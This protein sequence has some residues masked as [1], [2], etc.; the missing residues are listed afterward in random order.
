[1]MR[2]TWLLPVAC[3]VCLFLLGM[4]SVDPVLRASLEKLKP[5]LPGAYFELAEVVADNAKSDEERKLAIRL[6]ALAA[7]LDPDRWAHGGLLGISVLIE[8]DQ[9]R[10]RAVQALLELHDDARPN[11]LPQRQVVL[12][13]ESTAAVN[14]FDVISCMRT[15]DSIRARNLLRYG[16]GV[17]DLLEAYQGDV[18]GGMKVLLDR[19]TSRDGEVR[20]NEN[21]YVALLQVQSQLL[22]GKH[23]SW[24]ATLAVGLGRPLEDLSDADLG[25]VLKMDLEQSTWRNGRWT[26]P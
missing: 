20:L 14:A 18:P 1:M 25:N 5:S 19:I 3:V 13:A 15:G 21:V 6:F 7:T 10:I 24:S 22:G 17:R 23:E 16:S 4:Q 26:M 12:G 2:R 9:D 8:G 11:L